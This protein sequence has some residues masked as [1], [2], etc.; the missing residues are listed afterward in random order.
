MKTQQSPSNHLAR[1]T[2]GAYYHIYNRSHNRSPLF[3][4]EDDLHAFLSKY[5]MYLGD[6]VDTYAWCLMESHFHFC[7]RVKPA[8]VITEAVLEQ[9]EFERTAAQHLFL[10]ALEADR[11]YHS[12]VERQFIRM[13]AGYTSSFNQQ[14]GRSGNL[15][16]QPFQRMEIEDKKHLPWLVYYIHAEVVRQGGWPDF[17]EYPWSSYPLY[18]LKKP[19]YLRKKEALEWF[20]GLE[21]FVEFHEK[22][23]WTAEFDFLKMEE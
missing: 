20:G 6:Y 14:Y 22:E 15:F 10:E 11:D 2:P 4:T 5:K 7:I 3:R 18:A 17:S 21:R 12:V 23:S 9:P 8:E 13:F 19:T 1:F 16:H